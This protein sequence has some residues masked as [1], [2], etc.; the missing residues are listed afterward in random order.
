MSS[1][2]VP[3]ENT[4]SKGGKRDREYVLTTL[5]PSL[6]HWRSRSPKAFCVSQDGVDEVL[7]GTGN[8]DS[9]YASW[10]GLPVVLQVEL[11]DIKVPLRGKLL[12]D[13]GE[14]VRI[15]IDGS[16]I[17]IYKTMIL[18]VEEDAMVLL[19]A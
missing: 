5:V 15:R 8:M 10:I 18:A 9:A 11:G 4:R 19:P 7:R 12:K 16:D 3:R 13:K 14:T 2:F 1:T 17:D 6:Y